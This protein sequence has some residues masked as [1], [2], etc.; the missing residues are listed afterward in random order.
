VVEVEYMA[1][2]PTGRLAG[3]K[4]PRPRTYRAPRECTMDKFE[5]ADTGSIGVL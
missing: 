3:T 5:V 2:T 1:L 4:V